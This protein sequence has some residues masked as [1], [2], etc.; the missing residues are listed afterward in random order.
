MPLS[1]RSNCAMLNACSSQFAHLDYANAVHVCACVFV[2]AHAHEWFLYADTA[3]CLS[4]VC[5]YVCPQASTCTYVGGQAATATNRHLLS[6][7]ISWACIPTCASQWMLTPLPVLR[8]RERC[9]CLLLSIPPVSSSLVR[10]SWTL[11]GAGGLSDSQVR[12]L[13]GGSGLG[14]LLVCPHPT[15]PFPASELG[16]SVHQGACCLAGRGP[17]GVLAHCERHSSA[18]GCGDELSTEIVCIS[19]CLC[20]HC[21]VCVC[22]V[23]CVCAVCAIWCVCACVM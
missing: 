1:F 22:S 13:S 2:C 17:S 18:L 21:V 4:P 19:V 23:L 15:I 6:N 14:W 9:L 7:T 12:F 10:S 5:L 8:S 16:C 3:A 11:K 20:M